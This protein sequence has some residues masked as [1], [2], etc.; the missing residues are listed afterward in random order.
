MRDQCDRIVWVP[1][2]HLPVFIRSLSIALLVRI[3]VA[4][5]KECSRHFGMA[6]EQFRKKLN[7]IGNSGAIRSRYSSC[8]PRLCSLISARRQS[9]LQIH[10]IRLNPK[11]LPPIRK[12][13]FVSSSV[14]QDL[15]QPI[16]CADQIRIQFE[17]LAKFGFSLGWVRER[18]AQ[19]TTHLHQPGIIP[20]GQPEFVDCVRGLFLPLPDEP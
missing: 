5:G 14:Q 8:L 2:G 17:R 3:D 4:K 12:G 13:G 11:C 6:L 20:Q 9:E 15:R 16:E 10:V 7:G 18:R 19:R 1:A